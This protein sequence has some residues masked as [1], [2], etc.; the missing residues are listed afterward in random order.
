[1]SKELKEL[2]DKLEVSKRF[3]RDAYDS[4][5][6]KALEKD[7]LIAELRTNITDL[8]M[9]IKDLEEQSKLTGMQSELFLD[10]KMKELESMK[11]DRMEAQ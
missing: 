2:K 4:S 8:K 10:Q 7:Q 6:D 3:A 5:K 1:M 11:R 9:K